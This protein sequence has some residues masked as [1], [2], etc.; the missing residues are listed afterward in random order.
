MSPWT[1]QCVQNGLGQGQTDLESKATVGKSCRL[2]SDCAA[3]TLDPNTHPYCNPKSKV[4][5]YRESNGFV[6]V[7][8]GR[9]ARSDEVLANSS[10][11]QRIHFVTLDKEMRQERS[12]A[13][14]TQH[15][16]QDIIDDISCST[17]NPRQRWWHRRMCIDRRLHRSWHGSSEWSQQVVRSEQRRM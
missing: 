6:P 16:E 8:T 11:R 9:S 5:T 7:M 15:S 4:C 2:T 10:L 14:Q 13:G 12:R 17:A 3:S 1:K